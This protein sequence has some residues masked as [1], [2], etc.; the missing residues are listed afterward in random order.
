MYTYLSEGLDFLSPPVLN[1]LHLSCRLRS[2]EAQVRHSESTARSSLALKPRYTGFPPSGCHERSS[3]H[4]EVARPGACMPKMAIYHLCITSRIFKNMNYRYEGMIQVI[5]PILLLSACRSQSRICDNDVLLLQ[6]CSPQP[7]H[8]IQ[9]PVMYDDR[10]EWL[11]ILAGEMSLPKRFASIS[12]AGM[13][14]QY[15]AILGIRA[16]GN[17]AS[18]RWAH[19]TW[20]LLGRNQ[21]WLQRHRRG[22]QNCCTAYAG[23]VNSHVE[24]QSTHVDLILYRV[25]R[26]W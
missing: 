21:I 14:R 12:D 4:V 23:C 9:G 6:R 11:E 16:P 20:H 17:T 18:T 3:G 26:E 10:Q 5:V 25:L 2:S 1:A 8:H 13:Q 19:D 24:V 7:S 22:A 15:G